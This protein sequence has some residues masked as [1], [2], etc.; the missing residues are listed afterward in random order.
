MRVG[1]LAAGGI[2]RLMAVTLNNLQHPEI[3]LYAIAS[4]S[5]ER[6]D[7]FAKEF[8]VPVAYGS[9]E[10]LAADP[11]VDLIYI[12][13]PHSEH[14]ANAMMCM[15]HNKALL[16]EKAFTANAATAQEV[17]DY[18]KQH[19]ILVAEAIWTRYMPSRT[20]IQEALDKGLIGDVVG[21]QAN[22]GYPITHKARI[23]QPELAG[24]ALLDLGVYPINFAMMFFGHELAD[25]TGS[26]VKGETG[27]DYF[28]NICLTFKNGKMASLCANA[29]GPTDRSGIIF[30]SKA[31]LVVTNINNPEKVEVFDHTH[32]KIGELPLPKQVTGYE[33]QVISCLNALKEGRIECPEMPHQ[34]IMDVMH[35]MDKLRNDWGIKYPFE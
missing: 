12:A 23:S 32:T 25:I 19:N 8:N 1:I 33:Y 14:Y 28:E 26:C 6:A 17:L 30:G 31:Y 21:I 4:R 18:A 27:L 29:C 34:H 13:T 2:A 35:V 5:K 24:G 9:Y 15:Q 3:E 7:A 16:I 20:I 10:E 22:L 11:Q